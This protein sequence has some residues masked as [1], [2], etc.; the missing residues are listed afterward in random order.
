MTE[1]TRRLPEPL[2]K[3][4]WNFRNFCRHFGEILDLE[5]PVTATEQTGT[6]S[7]HNGSPSGAQHSG[8]HSI[9]DEEIARTIAAA[10]QINARRES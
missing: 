1:Q 10:E 8:A 2:Q 6:R 3:P 7:I 4:Y 5:K 9:S